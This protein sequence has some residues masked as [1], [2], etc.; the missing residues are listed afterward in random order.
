METQIKAKDALF[1]DFGGICLRCPAE[2]QCAPCISA[3]AVV[4][5]RKGLS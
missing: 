1:L 3:S 2:Q 5:P 4:I